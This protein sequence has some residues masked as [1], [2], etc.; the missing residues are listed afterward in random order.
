MR[1]KTND[2]PE[3]LRRLFEHMDGKVSG[4]DVL[5]WLADNGF[6]N[7]KAVHR[8]FDEPLFDTRAKS[9][10]SIPVDDTLVIRWSEHVTR[11]V[12]KDPL[13]PKALVTSVTLEGKIDGVTGDAGKDQFASTTVLLDPA[14]QPNRQYAIAMGIM[15]IVHAIHLMS[16]KENGRKLL[17]RIRDG[18]CWRSRAVGMLKDGFDIYNRFF[19]QEVNIRAVGGKVI[20]ALMIDGLQKEIS[21]EVEKSK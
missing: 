20:T 8:S 10:G 3:V 14:D 17:D 6:L 5:T 19:G 4:A 2:R 15:K 7:M 11:S 9:S 16:G 21:A 18:K 13:S 1:Q 12:E